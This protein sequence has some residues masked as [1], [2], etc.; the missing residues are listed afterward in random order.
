VLGVANALTPPSLL[1][2]ICGIGWKKMRLLHHEERDKVLRASG[3]QQ[4]D[5]A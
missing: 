3:Q 5:V 2:E 4:G 1:D